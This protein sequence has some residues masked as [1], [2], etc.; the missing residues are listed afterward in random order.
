MVAGVPV[1][2]ISTRIIIMCT[3][4]YAYRKNIQKQGLPTK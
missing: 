1:P 3:G 2:K 4:F